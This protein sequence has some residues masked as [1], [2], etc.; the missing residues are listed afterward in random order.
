MCDG[1]VQSVGLWDERDRKRNSIFRE[2]FCSLCKVFAVICVTR[3]WKCFLSGQNAVPVT[4][5]QSISV[6]FV[7]RLSGFLETKIQRWTTFAELLIPMTRS[8]I[9]VNILIWFPFDGGHSISTEWLITAIR[10]WQLCPIV[11][12]QAGL[13][14]FYLTSRIRHD[15]S[16]S[17][18]DGTR[19]SSVC[20]SAITSRR[21]E[22]YMF[23]KLSQY[24]MSYKMNKPHNLDIKLNSESQ[25]FMMND[26]RT[27]KYNQISMLTCSIGGLWSFPAFPN[28]TFCC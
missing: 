24:S 19:I 28:Q 4:E 21:A 16:Y 22:K 23:V 6:V 25:D 7:W 11:P 17:T 2:L 20:T 5:L 12:N 9:L 10:S 26:T 27:T 13:S 1:N 8:F 15:C 14:R 18:S 3:R